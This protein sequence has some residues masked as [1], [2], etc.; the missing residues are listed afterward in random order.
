MGRFTVCDC[1]GDFLVH[2]I[3]REQRGDVPLV[4]VPQSKPI[5]LEEHK[6]VSVYPQGSR[7]VHEDVCLGDV[8]ALVLARVVLPY[9]LPLQE[10][11]SDKARVGHLKV[12]WIL[13]FSVHR[14][15]G[16]WVACVVC[17]VL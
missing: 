7:E 9:A 1:H 5:T 13:V 3:D 16:Y 17:C 12:V 8:H 10:F 6:R 2:G 4:P 14:K 15:R 11:P